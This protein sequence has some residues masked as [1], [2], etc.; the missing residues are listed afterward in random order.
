MLMK[1][2]NKGQIV[3]PAEMRRAL[4]IQVGDRLDVEIDQ[5]RHTIELH[6]PDERKSRELAGAFAGYAKGRAFPAR[7]EMQ[8]ALAKG[9]RN[10]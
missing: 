2:F 4:G 7:E 10:G 8:D 1:V 5:E 6:K 3:I 9:L